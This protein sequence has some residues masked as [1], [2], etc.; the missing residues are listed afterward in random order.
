LEVQ[1]VGA[2]VVNCANVNH[3]DVATLKSALTKSQGRLVTVED[4]QLIGGFGQMLCHALLQAGVEFKVKSLGVHG[5]FGQSAYTALDL[6]KKHHID[7][8]A[9]VNAAK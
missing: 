6:Y 1:G 3:V 2:I 7:A 9:I 5:E 4:H 8:S